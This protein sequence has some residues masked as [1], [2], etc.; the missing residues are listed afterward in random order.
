M[1][2]GIDFILN[3]TMP[4]AE[5]GVAWYNYLEMI[6]TNVLVTIMVNNLILAIIHHY[7]YDL[8]YIWE[9]K[10]KRRKHFEQLEPNVER[11]D[12]YILHTTGVRNT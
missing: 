5:C 12:A 1:L 4:C 9:M 6:V 8:S 3:C 7:R 10:I 2:N 11:Y